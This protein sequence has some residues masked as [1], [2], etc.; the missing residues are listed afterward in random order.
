MQRQL[1][2]EPHEDLHAEVHGQSSS[3]PPTDVD[4]DGSVSPSEAP[5]G[6]QHAQ[7]SPL[8][9]PPTKGGGNGFTHVLLVKTQAGQAQ[10][11]LDNQ[12]LW[13]RDKFSTV[14]EVSITYMLIDTCTSE[15]V[16]SG[17]ESAVESAHGKI[18]DP[19]TLGT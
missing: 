18:G 13:W 4:T 15:I 12:P 7:S 5:H 2:D 8:Q 6:D 1:H 11:M 9:V 3:V 19:P 14:V 10:Q 17:T 16:A